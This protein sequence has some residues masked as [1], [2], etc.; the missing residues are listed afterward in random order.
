[1]SITNLTQVFPNALRKHIFNAIQA[2]TPVFVW[3]DPGIGKSRIIQALV[4]ALGYHFEDIRLSQIESIDLRG[5]PAKEEKVR[6]V[7]VL[8]SKGEPVIVAALDENN[9][10]KTVDGKAVMVQKYDREVETNVVW[11]KPDF[12]VRAEKAMREL[13]KPTAYFFDELNSGSPATMAAAYQFINDR[14]IGCFTLGER[15]VVLAAGNLETNGGITNM[16]PLPLA[17]RFRHYQMLMNSKQWLDFASTTGIHPWVTAY[18]SVQGNGGKL[19]QFDAEAL[20][21]SSEKSYATP[22]SWEMASKAIWAAFGKQ[23]SNNPLKASY[24]DGE[25]ESVFAEDIFGEDNDF[26]MSIKDLATIVASC[27]GSPIATD[28]SA[29]VN[30]GMDLPTAED[31]LD[32]KALK[33]NEKNGKVKDNSSSQYFL[34]GSCCYGLLEVRNKL[35]AMKETDGVKSEA[36]I[37]LDD[38]YNEKIENFFRFAEQY[39]NRELFIF[40]VINLM[41]KRFKVLPNPKKIDKDVFNHLTKEFNKARMQED[42]VVE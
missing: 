7:P 2:K 12:L 42:G 29:F 20:I 19:Q 31:I 16:M 1:M 17:N 11:S 38:K 21:G 23:N 13:G 24:L 5:L 26:V 18:L 37:K 28:F 6:F 3:G 8:D 39:F 30:N 41:I 40:A 9:Q 22:R 15:D 25:E 34:A 36:Y 35:L 4:E 27:V 33:P 32:G 14:R 10:V